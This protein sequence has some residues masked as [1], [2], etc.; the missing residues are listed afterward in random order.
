MNRS[1][2]AW[3]A[4]AIGIGWL[5]G[6]AAGGGERPAAEP[7]P[8]PEV[9]PDLDARLAELPAAPLRVSSSRLSPPDQELMIRLI[10]ACRPVDDIFLRQSDARNPQLRRLLGTLALPE[11]EAVLAYFDAHHGIYERHR[12]NEAF[13]QGLGDKPAGAGLYPEELSLDRWRSYLAE[14]PDREAEL[15]SMTTVVRERD[16]E[17]VGVPY[18]EA[19]AGAIDRIAGAVGEAA[20]LTHNPSL[21]RYLRALERALH[22]DDYAPAE[23][24]WIDVVSRVSLTLGPHETVEDRLF[25]YKA[26]FEGMVTVTDPQATERALTLAGSLAGLLPER[27]RPG[28][29]IGARDIPRLEVADL[30]F[31]AGR[32]RSAPL[33]LAFTF[34][35]DERVRRQRGEKTIL[36]RN[37]AAAKGE[38][39]LEP[40]ADAALA[41]RLAAAVGGDALLALAL[42][43]Q[44]AHRLPAAAPPSPASGESRAEALL[45]TA[46]PLE[47]LRAD[48][49]AVH[50]LLTLAARAGDEEQAR[51]LTATWLADLLRRARLEGTPE[52]AV[53]VLQLSLL[54][55]ADGLATEPTLSLRPP[56]LRDAA[57]AWLAT[58]DRIEADGDY[59][60]ARGLLDRH[61]ALPPELR[62]VVG[63]LEGLPLAVRAVFP[64]AGEAAGDAL[65]AKNS[66]N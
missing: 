15:I 66:R 33:T 40:I 14:N 13:V 9:A 56:R 31:A 42:A 16:G 48:A 7:V 11:Q 30:A 32:A 60:G 22:E 44:L 6:C 20:R 53:A 24:A 36:L 12:R 19:Y 29:R 35:A 55:R 45:E 64:A 1:T 26:V 58:I 2:E 51:S 5:A 57:G 63:G 61:A 21:E 4:L 47:E 27:S 50:H 46:P 62:E 25:G 37:V 38:R 28:E 3:I 39:I 8:P 18:S 49:W 34:P 52:A 17:L 65:F 23:A 59:E 10:E 43:H 54:S 41:P